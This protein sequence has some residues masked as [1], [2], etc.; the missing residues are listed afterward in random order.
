M[1]IQKVWLNLFMNI[2]RVKSG[3]FIFV[4]NGYMIMED[5]G[6]LNIEKYVWMGKIR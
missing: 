1:G 5:D 2:K 4:L 3:F 6:I